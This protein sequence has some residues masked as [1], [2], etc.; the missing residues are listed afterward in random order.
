MNGGTP[1]TPATHRTDAFNCVFCQAYAHQAWGR[2]PLIA[3][4]NN[5]GANDRFWVCRCSHCEQFSYW[6]DGQMV[7]PPQSTAPPPNSDLPKEIVA[8]YEEARSI[9]AKS[10][11]GAAALL[12]LAIQKLC[13]ELGES[14]S[15]INSDIATLVKKGL[16]PQV[17]K[18]LDIVRVVGN[19]A[20]HPGQI[21]LNDDS[22]IA[23]KLFGLVNVIAEIMI[24]QPKHVNEMFESVVPEPQRDAI[25]KRDGT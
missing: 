24:T 2:P 15:N 1:Y 4:S 7:F 23:Y 11:R 21:D 14:G 22:A 19:N 13:K 12:R 6:V 3:G 8:D 25:K 16:P 10:P 17:Q 18:A 20:V 5:F 9:V